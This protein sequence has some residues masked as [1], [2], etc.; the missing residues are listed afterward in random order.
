M[1]PRALLGRLK[2]HIHAL[3]MLNCFGS[4][5]MP[6]KQSCL[7]HL[8][9][10]NTFHARTC[11]LKV[12]LQEIERAVDADKESCLNATATWSLVS[13]ILA[14]SE[15]L[16]RCVPFEGRMLYITLFFLWLWG[17]PLKERPIA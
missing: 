6:L 15:A 13:S 9:M 12:A 16:S 14:Q 8:W 7:G 11:G 2:G 10:P 17:V 3:V 1:Q 5:V 4:S